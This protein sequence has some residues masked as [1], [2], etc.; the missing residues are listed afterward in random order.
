MGP[1]SGTVES[2]ILFC[3]DGGFAH[4][5]HEQV[6]Q[7]HGNNPPLH[8]PAAPAPPSRCQTHWHAQPMLGAM[9]Q[10]RQGTSEC[11]LATIMGAHGQTTTQALDSPHLPLQR[12]TITIRAEEAENS[13]DLV[14]FELG[15]SGCGS[16]HK[17]FVS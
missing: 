7:N 2:A 6:A 14:V 13:S 10:S 3:S 11:A 8:P 17:R 16:R 12:A 1:A 15:A 5:Q 9:Q 4:V